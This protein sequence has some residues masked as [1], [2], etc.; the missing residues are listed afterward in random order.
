[1]PLDETLDA[2]HA[3]QDKTLIRRWG[4]SNFSVEDM[5]EFATRPRR[6]SSVPNKSS[7]YPAAPNAPTETSVVRARRPISPDAPG[8]RSEVSTNQ[9][10]HNLAR[11]GIE[12]D[13]LLWCR[14]RRVPIM[15]YPPLDQGDLSGHAVL[16]AVAHSHAAT[17]T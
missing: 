11:R 16:Q 7:R 13:L 1:V 14:A 10:L 8:D 17:P 5:K 3:L 2:F 12:Y 4:V 6:A 9:V 15:A